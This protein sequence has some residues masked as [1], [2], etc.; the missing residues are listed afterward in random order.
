M[1]ASLAKV[2][3]C[4]RPHLWLFIALN[5]TVTGVAAGLTASYALIF[6][7]CLCL[8]A[9]FGF[10]LNDLVD[11]QIDSDIHPDRLSSADHV[12]LRLA[13]LSLWI[14]LLFSLTISYSLG[15]RAGAVAISIA[16][17]L[18]AYSLVF[19][20]QLLVATIICSA[21]SISPLWAPYIISGSVIP[22]FHL[23][24]VAAGFVLLASREI[25][26]DVK[27]VAGDLVGKRH[28]I[29]TIMGPRISM[30]VV[31]IL[32]TA[33]YLTL[34][35]TCVWRALSFPLAAAALVMIG[36]GGVAWLTIWPTARLVL[37]QQ[38]DMQLVDIYVLQTRR[39]MA[40]I[41]LFIIV[42]MLL[43]N[44]AE[45]EERSK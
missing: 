13:H 9:A 20:K 26:L 19:R 38:R 34:F 2:I 37:S 21:S 28:T 27:D 12:T 8:L 3:H 6:G 42:N 45:D 10:I 24:I 44:S 31:V 16:I 39:A 41:P 23:A 29:A 18:S 40:L 7:F 36:L 14:I 30:I 32:T 25:T 1:K 35:V 15:A 17:T 5:T 43:G 22:S 4:S 33:G 11:R